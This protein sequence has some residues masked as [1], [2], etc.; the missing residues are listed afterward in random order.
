MSSNLPGQT[1]TISNSIPQLDGTS[2]LVMTRYSPITIA[3]V[4]LVKLII[5]RSEYADLST[6]ILQRL[7]LSGAMCP[8]PL[9][10]VLQ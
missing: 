5:L 2:A 9:L 3:S 4:S 1:L 6:K 7:H 8:K 10:H